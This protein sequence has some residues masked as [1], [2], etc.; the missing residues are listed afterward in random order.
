MR[1]I[2]F[3]ILLFIIVGAINWGLWGIFQYDLVADIFGGNTTALARLVYSIVGISGVL[4][5]SFF[6]VPEIYRCNYKKIKKGGE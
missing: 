6:F 3:F 1:I 2:K 5:I 4:G